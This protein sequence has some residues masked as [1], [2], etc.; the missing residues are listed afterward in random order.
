MSDFSNASYITF[1]GFVL[2]IHFLSSYFSTETWLDLL[3]QYLF[4]LAS[5]LLILQAHRKD[6]QQLFFVS[7]CLAESHTLFNKSGFYLSLR[8]R[9]HHQSQCQKPIFWIKILEQKCCNLVWVKNILKSYKF[10]LMLKI[11]MLWKTPIS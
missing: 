8:Q 6:E 9:S 3:R 2:S 4:L 7:Q 1:K 11:S 10:M 5:S